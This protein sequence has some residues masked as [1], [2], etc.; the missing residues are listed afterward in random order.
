MAG[1]RSFPGRKRY[2]IVNECI[3]EA[4]LGRTGSGAGVIVCNGTR[5]EDSSQAHGTWFATGIERAA[6][7]LKSA[8][9]KAGGA[10]RH[11]FS[12]R[13]RIV[14]G[15]DRVDAGGDQFFAFN[16]K[17]AEGTT[18]ALAHIINR[19]IDGLPH[20]FFMRFRHMCSDV[21]QYSNG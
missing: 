9:S 17:G 15:G 7:Q 12:M 6:I 21:Q 5:P 18:V 10:D 1:Y 19:Q 16:D 13:R 11:N 2:L 8:E 4:S 14:I 20:P 3:V